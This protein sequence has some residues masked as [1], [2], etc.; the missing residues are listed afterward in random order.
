MLLSDHLTSLR[1]PTGMLYGEVFSCCHCNLTKNQ[2]T[3][4]R[5]NLLALE[6]LALPPPMLQIIELIIFN[7]LPLGLLWYHLMPYIR[8]YQLYL[9]FTNN[10][11]CNALVLTWFLSHMLALCGLGGNLSDPAYKIT[12]LYEKCLFK[13]TRKMWSDSSGYM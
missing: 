10:F 4:N 2:L 9:A 7:A 13:C 5:I 8:C 1:P 11:W 6:I 3:D 12:F